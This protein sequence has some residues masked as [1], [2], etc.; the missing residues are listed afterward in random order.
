MDKKRFT[1]FK[2]HWAISVC[3]GLM[4]LLD[5]TL[6][7]QNKGL[8]NDDAYIYFRYATNFAQ[9]GEF[10]FNPH[11]TSYGFTSL[12]WMLLLAVNIWLTSFNPIIISKIYVIIFHIGAI[13]MMYRIALNL[14]HNNKKLG[15]IV[16]CLFSLDGF[17]IDSMLSGME[18]AMGLFFYL[19]VVA[20]VIGCKKTSPF[21]IGLFVQCAALTRPE[22]ILL[23]PAIILY[24]FLTI[25]ISK[26]GTVRNR[27]KY[28]VI[29]VISSSFLLMPYSL[30]LKSTTG[31]FTASPYVGKILTTYPDYFSKNV[32]ERVDVGIDSIGNLVRNIFV[33]SDLRYFGFFLFLSI[34]VCFQLIWKGF[35]KK[36]TCLLLLMYS[37]L[38]MHF[39]VYICTYPTGSW[40]YHIQ[41]FPIVYLGLV[42][43]INTLFMD[44]NPSTSLRNIRLL[45][46]SYGLLIVCFCVIWIERLMYGLPQPDDNDEVVSYEPIAK[47]LNTNLTKESLVAL[48]M[49]GEI[50]YLSQVRIFDLGG[51]IDPSIWPCLKKRDDYK[52]IFE[53]FKS[54]GVTHFLTYDKHIIWNFLP[55]KIGNLELLEKV[56][57]NASNNNY[58][59]IYRID[60]SQPLKI[61][62]DTS[63]LP[64][65]VKKEIIR[66]LLIPI[67]VENS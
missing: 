2:K 62:E 51:L 13:L 10:A 16:V 31:Y 40:R 41:T 61:L 35:Y 18:T 11:E 48:D 38:L 1:R 30:F 52:L 19:S 49:I 3:C 54:K 20:V 67:E 17:L 59:R 26:E 23:L 6:T 46:W 39:T 57:D 36:K 53:L 32:F 15:L 64:A 45:R 25:V 29:L 8:N 60:Y 7:S 27:I 55:K 21:V 58:F 37:E 56:S 66:K 4:L 65:P 34:P 12:S 22:Y 14:S 44:L 50:S 42:L 33:R 5:I 43:G 28:W 47:W 9:H 63:P 24:E